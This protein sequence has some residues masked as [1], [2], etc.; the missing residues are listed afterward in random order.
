MISVSYLTEATDP[1]HTQ[2]KKHENRCKKR[3]TENST[4][5]KKEN[6]EREYILE[7]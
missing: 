1:D 7:I 5:E 3:R 6:I 4:K 2:T